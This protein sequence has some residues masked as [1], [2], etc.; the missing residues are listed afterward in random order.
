[1]RVFAVLVLPRGLVGRAISAPKVKKS[2]FWPKPSF[3]KGDRAET[4]LTNHVALQPPSSIKTAVLARKARKRR[5]ATKSI[6]SNCCRR[7]GHPCPWLAK[8]IMSASR[9]QY[10]ISATRASPS[11]LKYVRRGQKQTSTMLDARSSLRLR[12][13]T[14]LVSISASDFGFLRVSLGELSLLSDLLTV[15]PLDEAA[16]RGRPVL[17]AGIGEAWPAASGFA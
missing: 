14:R 6:C 7:A 9:A 16:M 12:C 10:T 2:I 11:A 13:K 3:R 5:Y 4:H 8:P 15:S 17:E 1:L